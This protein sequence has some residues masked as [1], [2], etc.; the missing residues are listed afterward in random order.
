MEYNQSFYNYFVNYNNRV[1]LFNGIS[2]AIFSVSKNEF[3]T[4]IQKS[5]TDLHDTR[6]NQPDLFNFLLN[7]QFIYHN[8]TNEYES[9]KL[10]NTKSVFLNKLYR[11]V[12]IPTLNCNFN[13]WY[14]YEEHCSD[15]MS[16]EI[17]ESI[18]KHIYNIITKDKIPSILL[19]WY[20]GEPL[21]CF[22]NIIE[23]IASY[24]IDLCNKHNVRFSQLITTNGYLTDKHIE[25]IKKI[26]LTNF[27][28][29]LDGT[30]EKHNKVRN[31]NGEGTFNKIISNIILLCENIDNVHIT[32]RINYDNNTLNGSI[33]EI[34]KLIPEEH[35]SKITPNLQRVWQTHDNKKNQRDNVINLRDNWINL[36]YN[37]GDSS[38]SFSLFC[39][40]K[41]YVDRYYHT[42]INYDGKV[43]K[44]T[45]RD[46]SEEQSAGA[47]ENDGTIKWKEGFIEKMYAKPTFENR[48]CIKCKHLPICAGPCSQKI[49]ET[50][51]DELESICDLN[52]SE[53][54]I[55]EFII[56]LYKEK[57]RNTNAIQMV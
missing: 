15:I 25:Q 14:C 46:F 50:P 1:I 28:I 30:E 31:I 34:L 42:E 37:K 4:I 2:G 45:A 47:L 18:K 36:K 10:R 49:R 39:S 6:V 27:Q 13:C 43:F 23:P 11:L 16:Q 53:I 51:E 40:H 21:L 35:R 12:L 38:N 52:F 54:S 44:C 24:C 19:D 5:L 20:G 48:M 57:Q 56:E 32:L 8:N 26:N 22:E 17:I 3:E 33:S 29:T 55:E 41:C 9:I 7:H